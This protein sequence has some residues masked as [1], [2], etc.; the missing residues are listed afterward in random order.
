MICK[1][2][3]GTNPLNSAVGVVIELR[4]SGQSRA[5]GGV[6]FPPTPQTSLRADIVD[7]IYGYISWVKAVVWVTDVKQ[8]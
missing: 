6:W 4:P 8:V 5:A 1:A 2:N 3:Q 7:V